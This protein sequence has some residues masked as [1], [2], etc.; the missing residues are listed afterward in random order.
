MKEKESG[1]PNLG[2]LERIKEARKLLLSLLK[3]RIPMEMALKMTVHEALDYVD[4][5]AEMSKPP[6]PP[7]YKVLHKADGEMKSL[8][9]PGV[10]AA[11]AARKGGE[12]R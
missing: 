12:R 10:G 9:L 1:A 11:D 5:W 4:A 6:G 2:P 3:L 8:H 7:K